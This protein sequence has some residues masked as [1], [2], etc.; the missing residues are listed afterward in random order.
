MPHITK[1]VAK[2]QIATELLKIFTAMLPKT[3]AKIQIT[4]EMLRVAY[5]IHSDAKSQESCS[6]MLK[7]QIARE[8]LSKNGC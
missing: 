1:T 8:L 5:S 7:M 6:E 2:I 4:T 3:V